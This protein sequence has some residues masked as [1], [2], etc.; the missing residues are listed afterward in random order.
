[1]PL[2]ESSTPAGQKRKRANPDADHHNTENPTTVPETT[3]PC[4]QI[5]KRARAS[6]AELTE[7][8]I[9]SDVDPG[10]NSDSSV[11]WGSRAT[12]NKAKR[13]RKEK[14]ETP[15]P[16]LSLPSELRTKIYQLALEDPE[17]LVMTEGRHAHRRVPKRGRYFQ[18]GNQDKYAGLAN[19]VRPTTKKPVVEP[20]V[21]TLVPALLAVSKQVYAEAAAILYAQPLHFESTTALHSFLALLTSQTASLIRSITIH[22]YE[23]R[24]RGMRK[25][26]NV[27]ALTLLR[28]CSNLQKL[29][30]EGY[31]IYSRGPLGPEEGGKR[32][33]VAVARQ[34]YRD[35]AFWLDT[36]DASKALQIL[37]LPVFQS[38]TLDYHFRNRESYDDEM[39]TL[40][41][42]NIAIAEELTRLI[43]RTGKPKS[44]SKKS[45]TARASN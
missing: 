13:P 24:S 31:H 32:Q 26:M 30:L 20:I 2:C 43:Q 17:G 40:K 36:I 28:N 15:F 44:K 34:I 25:A 12:Q 6:Y 27:S 4:R 33:G 22:T 35:A 41:H 7:S 16:F 37:D 1:M 18:H 42:V 10:H 8:D 23:T 19:L 38:H 9:E 5:R 29:C 21:Y 11:E 3:R 39:E 14:T 45:K